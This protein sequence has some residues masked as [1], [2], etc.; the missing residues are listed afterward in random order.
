MEFTDQQLREMLIGL[1]RAVLLAQA[2]ANAYGKAAASY[3]IVPL[4]DRE[5]ER[6]AALDLMRPLEEAL[7][8]SSPAEFVAVFRRM[9]PVS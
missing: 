1:A 2:D 8:R 7:A 6:A 4:V 9:F 5:K 3:G